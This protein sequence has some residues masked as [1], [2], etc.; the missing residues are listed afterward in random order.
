LPLPPLAI[1][2]IKG[3][4]GHS[5]WLFPSRLNGRALR[6]FSAAQALFRLNKRM[7]IETNFTPHDLRRTCASRLGDLGTPDEVIGRILNHAPVTITGK[8]YNRAQRWEEMREAL[9]AWSEQLG[10]LVSIP[11]AQ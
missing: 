9:N 7:N 11:S 10:A 5:Q 6:P 1:D 8:V 3:R 4:A 2:I